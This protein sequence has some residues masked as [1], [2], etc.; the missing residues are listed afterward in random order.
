[1]N[2]NG[3]KRLTAAL[4]LALAASS[5]SATI[6]WGPYPLTTVFQDDNIDGVFNYV[7]SNGDGVPD[8]LTPDTDGNIDVNDVLVAIFELNSANGVPIGPDQELTGVTVIQFDHFADIDGSGGANDMVFRPFD[9]GMNLLLN[10]VGVS[11]PDDTNAVVAAWLDDSPDLEISADAFNGGSNSCATLASCLTQATDGMLW[12]VDILDTT[13]DPDNFWIALNAQTN[14]D[15]VVASDPALAF[16]NV[17][18]GLSIL[19]N[20]TGKNLLTDSISCFPYCGGVFAGV[21]N[22]DVLLSGS[23]K[24]GNVLPG[25]LVDEGFVATSDFDTTKRVPEPASL[26]LFGIGMIGF[27]LLQGRAK[28]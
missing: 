1:M 5:A 22:V 14:T 2:R 25:S 27:R 23:I 21:G 8:S 20:G 24:G 13:I 18:A 7:D 9:G 26:A 10:T 15:V 16:G 28:A 6:N 12:E 19:Y 3:I 11:I 17:N 4:T